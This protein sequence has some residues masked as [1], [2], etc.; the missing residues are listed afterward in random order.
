VNCI[1]R[2]F[3]TGGA[4]LAL[5]LA[6]STADAQCSRDLE[7]KGNRICIDG[8]CTDMPEA[9]EASPAFPA[10]PAPAAPRPAPRPA[11]ATLAPAPVA[12]S[13]APVYQQPAPVYPQPAPIYQQPAFVYQ[14]PTR[15]EVT[16]RDPGWARAAGYLGIGTMVLVTGL[17][18]GIVANNG[19]EDVAIP[20]GIGA[21]VLGG[22]MIPIVAGGG[23]SARN[24]PLVQGYPGL[25][26]AS[27]I[28][29]GLSLADALLAIGLGLSDI[30]VPTP[31]VGSIGLLGVLS[32]AGMTLDA[33]ESASSA[34]AS[35]A[36]VQADHGLAVVPFLGPVG[37]E[38]PGMVFGVRGSL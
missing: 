25:R 1:L 38:H 26:L 30:E 18:I 27:W 6:T 35:N 17:T 34:D 8:R 24:N 29:Y 16:G 36:R 4:F 37:R 23:S 5:S 20:L 28:V 13:P 7:C 9:P 31:V 21:T 33:F 15:P 19:D 12:P 3:M 11:P 10:Q 22:A 14:Q 2:V 32:T